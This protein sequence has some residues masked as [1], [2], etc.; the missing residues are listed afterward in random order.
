M[1][2]NS[3][4]KKTFDQ[5]QELISQGAKEASEKKEYKEVDDGQYECRVD[6][7]QIKPTKDGRPMLEIVYEIE[8]KTND[9]DELDTSYSGKIW[10]YIVLMGT[11]NDG[12]M[13]Y[14]AQHTLG[15]ISQFEFSG[16]WDIDNNR[17]QCDWLP[18]AKTANCLVERKT[19]K[20]GFTEIK[21]V[22][23]WDD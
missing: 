7:T 22:D 6:S 4:Y 2:I 9:D 23:V 17:L 21:L 5:L 8:G 12:Y 13:L 20:K 14:L 1:N 18:V 15:A 19:N 11:K 16:D 3:E 10:Q